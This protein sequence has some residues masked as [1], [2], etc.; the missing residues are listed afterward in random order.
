LKA[1]N[2]FPG[3]L[4]LLKDHILNEQK[5]AAHGAAGFSPVLSGSLAY[6]VADS[7]SSSSS[8]KF[9]MVERRAQVSH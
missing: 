9:Q 7:S 8:G 2:N 3:E 4:I 1:A 5:P 6:F